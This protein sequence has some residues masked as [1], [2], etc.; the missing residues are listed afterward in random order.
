MLTLRRGPA[1]AV[2]A[3]VALVLT[4]ACHDS[5]APVGPS[6]AEG[7]AQLAKGGKQPYAITA[8]SLASSSVVLEGNGTDY[9]VVLQ[10]RTGTALAGVFIQGEILQGEARFGAGGVYVQCPDQGV[11][12]PGS[13][14]MSWIVVASNQN[15]GVG[16]LVPGPAKFLLTLYQEPEVVLD[17]RTVPIRLVAP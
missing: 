17:T 16:T 11:L 8:L 12:G 3:V 1:G 10:N 7:G 13:C 6:P 14:T 2:L 5:A 15:A 9:Q 4:A